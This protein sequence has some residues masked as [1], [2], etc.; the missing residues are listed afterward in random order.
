M[1]II[2]VSDR[3][4]TARSIRLTWRH[5]VLLAA[6]LFGS[7][8]VMSSLFSYVTVR[9]AAE[10]R[11]SF[12]Q[13]MVRAVN[14]EEAQ[15]SKD[16]VRGNLNAMAVKLGEMQAQLLRLDTIGERLAAMAGVKP[17][18]LKAFETK[19]DG[20][21][22]PLVLPASMSST[23]LQR[24]V[25]ALANQVEAKSDTIS[26]IESQLLEDRIRKSLLPTSLPVEAQWNASTYGWRVDPFTG[27]RAMHEGVDFVANH[28]TGIRAAA[29][30]IVITAERHA[31]YGNMVEIDHGKE[32]TTRYAHASRILVKPGQLV[33][34]GQKIA[35]VGTTGRSTGPHL[36]FEVRIRGLAQ[37][38]DR[39][40]R[41]AQNAPKPFAQSSLA[42][43]R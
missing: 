41:I 8:L 33:K 29:A 30:G 12:L 21:G 5:A 19:V 35:E 13:D 15:R 6:A 31:Q 14:A 34:R 36:H 24:A 25:D 9:H 10:I 22:G 1:H 4:A 42:A 40:L 3:L 7:V 32:L 17:Q 2:L 18:E 28:G 26:M 11:L 20:R 16:F 39:F 23:D 37:N 38:P 43:R 27:E